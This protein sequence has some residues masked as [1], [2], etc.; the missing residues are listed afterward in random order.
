MRD[1]EDG[2]RTVFEFMLMTHWDEQERRQFGQSQSR[3]H[4]GTL[5]DRRGKTGNRYWRQSIT[6]RHGTLES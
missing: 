1:E 5:A 3:E 6:A 2:H 4:V